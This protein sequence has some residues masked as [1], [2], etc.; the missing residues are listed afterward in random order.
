MHRQRA[1]PA[2][3]LLLLATACGMGGYEGGGG[4]LYTWSLTV[5]N[6]AFAG[7]AADCDSAGPANPEWL[8]SVGFRENNPFTGERGPWH[9]LTVSV[10]PGTSQV[11]GPFQTDYAGPSFLWTEFRGTFAGGLTPVR[12]CPPVLLVTEEVRFRA[13]AP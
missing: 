9:D 13:P 6:S 11:L 4:T 10:A 2:A 3:L 1:V 8:V 12:I 5:A 7:D